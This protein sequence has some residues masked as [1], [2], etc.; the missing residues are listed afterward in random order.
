MSGLADHLWQSTIAVGIAGL[1]V[2]LCR[3]NR[4]AV[5]YA[6]WLAASL[7]FLVPFAALVTLGNA[8]EH[9]PVYRQVTE[10]I[11]VAVSAML[12]TLSTPVASTTAA[13]PAAIRATGSWLTWTLVAVWS[14]GVLLILAQRS[15]S[16]RRIRAAVLESAPFSVAHL[17]VP[18]GIELRVSPHVIE[19]GVAGFRRQVV[20]LP[21][22]IEERLSPAQLHAVL[23][24]EF[25]HASRRDNL[26]AAMHMV[27]ETVF[28]FHPLVWWIGARLVQERE[29]ACDEHVLLLTVDA[30]AYADG[31][32]SVCRHYTESP[33]SCVSGVNGGD[34]RSR[35]E[36]IMRNRTSLALSP[37]RCVALS[38]GLVAAIALPIAVG[39]LDASAVNAQS[40]ATLAQT[41]AFDAVS[42]RPVAPN[43]PPGMRT[44]QLGGGV[45]NV[46]GYDVQ[47]LLRLAFDMRWYQILGVP[48]W[49]TTARYNIT[50]R[51]ST[52]VGGKE[53]WRMLVPTLE[54]RF[55]MQAHREKQEMDVY[56]L[57]VERRGRLQE[58]TAGCFDPLGPLPKAVRTEHGQRPLLGCGQTF[59]LLGPRAGTLWGAKVNTATLALALTDLLKRHVVDDTGITN[60]FDLELRFALD[61]IPGMPPIPGADPFA[62]DILT[63]LRDQLGLKLVPGRAPVDVVVIDRIEPP[64]AN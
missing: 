22:G 37:A 49:A 24:H 47:Q 19:P 28:W 14:C 11:P 62:P 51:T 16:W 57:T 7:K 46:E 60:A 9:E 31:I 52:P 45:M 32:L 23:A 36:A 43:A 20:L 21:A 13:V 34:I 4:P 12:V 35:I 26:T 29:R 3:R 30:R 25:C 2:M 41:P 64:S 6:I 40:A 15:Q 56:K 1:L 33:L 8:I 61:S 44:L 42:I 27:V 58:A 5:R 54:D 10:Q 17:E 18:E 39:A 48:K 53:L 59:P 38:C 55:R 50:A 63:A